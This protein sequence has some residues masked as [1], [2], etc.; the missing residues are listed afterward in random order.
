MIIIAYVDPG[1]GLLAWQA[2]AAFFV[3][4]LFYVKKTRAYMARAMQKI[5]RIGRGPERQKAPAHME[6]REIVRK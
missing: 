6:R 3:G 4:L 2:L 1:L 5:V